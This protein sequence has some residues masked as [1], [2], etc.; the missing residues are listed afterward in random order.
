MTLTPENNDF[1][2][3]RT[4]LLLKWPQAL[5]RVQKIPG[6]LRVFHR[7]AFLF[8][9]HELRCD[10]RNLATSRI[11]PG[12]K[13]VCLWGCETAAKPF[14]CASIRT[15]D[16]NPARTA[17]LRRPTNLHLSW[18]YRSC[19]HMSRRDR[20]TSDRPHPLWPGPFPQ[21]IVQTGVPN[22][23][24]FDQFTGYIHYRDPTSTQSIPRLSAG[25]HSRFACSCKIRSTASVDTGTD[26]ASSR[27]A[28]GATL[29]AVTLFT[30]PLARTSLLD[31]RFCLL[32]RV[33]ADQI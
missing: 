11:R 9:R 8:L 32:L 29:S 4:S 16:C 12:C 21:S 14:V 19:G 1:H 15:S 25:N 7:A 10:L 2:F 20:P 26:R 22:L 28:R 3:T 5:G 27:I 31:Q 33:I 30:C 24:P 18:L 17:G 13:R 23:C 6:L